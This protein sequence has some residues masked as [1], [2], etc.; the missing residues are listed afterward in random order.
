LLLGQP[1]AFLHQSGEES[2]GVGQLVGKESF[3]L[4]SR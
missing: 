3:A 4:F 1:V 2:V